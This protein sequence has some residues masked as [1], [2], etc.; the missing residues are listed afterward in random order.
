VP[1]EVIATLPEPQLGFSGFISFPQIT[2]RL[3]SFFPV[4]HKLGL[5]FLRRLLGHGALGELES[6]EEIWKMFPDLLT[7]RG[8]IYH[9]NK[10]YIDYDG[11]Q[12]AEPEDIPLDK[13]P[14]RP[15]YINCTYYK[16]LL[17]NEEFEEA[18]MVSQYMSAEEVKK[19]FSEVFPHGKMVREGWD[20][21]HAKKLLNAAFNAISKDEEI[22]Y[23]H[24]KDGIWRLKKMGGATRKAL[25][26]LYQYAKPDPK[27]ITGLVS[28]VNLYI[29]ALKYYDDENTHK[30]MEGWRKLMFWCCQVE[31]WLA[32]GLG[33]VYLRAHV[34]GIG[35]QTT[36]RGCIMADGM[37]YFAFRLYSHYLPVVD[38][39]VGYKGVDMDT[40]SPYAVAMQKEPE[41]RLLFK[42][43]VGQNQIRGLNLCDAMN[44][45]SSVIVH[46]F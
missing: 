41:G 32:A 30:K 42:S 46:G 31:E 2:K 5:E 21:E 38:F 7:C 9:P 43:Y 45:A 18:E 15:G 19:Q 16:I 22:D 26:D 37:P 23:Y 28:D 11:N 6:G 10:F 34:Q 1:E 39:Y 44:Q 25:D 12:L 8:T 17:M 33:T 27:Q 29:A 24:D 14:G 4:Q 36:R 40:A 20:L 13:N 3:H 35:N